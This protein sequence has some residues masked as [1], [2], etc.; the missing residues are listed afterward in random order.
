MY[1][2]AVNHFLLAEGLVLLGGEPVGALDVRDRREAPAAPALPLVLHRSHCAR[3]APVV[4]VRQ[5]V[6]LVEQQGRRL[7]CVEQERYIEKE[8]PVIFVFRK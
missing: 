4:A 3:R 6:P 8:N 2:I 1:R 7:I 5:A